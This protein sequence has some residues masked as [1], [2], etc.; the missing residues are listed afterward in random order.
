MI[1]DR[2]EL[3]RKLVRAA[4]VRSAATMISVLPAFALL[5]AVGR[6]GAPTAIAIVF[7]IPALVAG[8]VTELH[9]RRSVTCPNCGASL[10]CC[11]TGSFK[12]RK[13]KVRPQTQA[14][15]GCDVPILGR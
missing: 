9:C 15:P 10:W 12:P 2:G 7:G 14:C 1:I 13:M 5:A 6:V 8:I 3:L 4:Q 11:G